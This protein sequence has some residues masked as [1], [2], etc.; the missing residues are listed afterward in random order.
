M[1]DDS[2]WYAVAF[3]AGYAFSVIF[4]AA[5]YRYVSNDKNLFKNAQ[6][7]DAAAWVLVLLFWFESRYM[8][9]FLFGLSS[10]F[11]RSLQVDL[12]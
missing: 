9:L 12:T 8:R 5:R 3:R 7:F 1:S 10:N 6:Q 2:N 4:L 11:T